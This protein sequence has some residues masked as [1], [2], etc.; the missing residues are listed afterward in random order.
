MS[1]IDER[2]VEMKFDNAGFEAG[3]KQST[4]SLGD[5]QGA[6]DFTPAANSLQDIS[7]KLSA[8]G[9]V[10]FTVIQ[11][12]TRGA[13]GYGAGLLNTIF[14]PI[15][16]GGK[17][18][19]LN[20]EQA[21]FQFKG[22]GM[23]VEASMNSAREAVLGTAY[24]LDA[25][26]AVASQL[27][28]SGMRAG[29]DMTS[30][31]RGVS[32]LAAMTG[33]SYE[34]IGSIFTTVAGN[35]RLMGDQ[36]LQLSTRGINAA[37]SLGESL[38][39]TEAQVREMVTK[40]EIDFETFYK[41]MDDAFGKHA[42]KASETFN[43]AMSNARAALSRIGAAFAAVDFENQRKLLNAVT[44]VID[45][46]GKAL[47]PVV[48]RFTELTGLS[49][50][51][52][53]SFLE[54]L[55]LD[56]FSRM[57]Y[58]A[59]KAFIS[60]FT[61]IMKV[62]G[63]VKLAFRDVFPPVSSLS[64]L[65]I[66][67]EIR[68]FL[69]ALEFS[70]RAL[71]RIR[72]TF[73]G[74]FAVF[75]IGIFLVSQLAKFVG[76]LL[77]EILP[78]SGIILEFSGGMG[79]L[80]LALRDLIKSENGVSSFFTML[81]DG[82]VAAIRFIRRAV[83]V[84]KDFFGALEI[85]VPDL[86]GFEAVSDIVGTMSSRLEGLGRVGDIIVAIF[87]GIV[88]VFGAIWRFLQPII[89]HIRD[90]AVGI[91]DALVEA[92][93]AADYNAILDTLNI[94]LL[95]SI[96]F[97][98]RSFLNT[99]VTESGGG[100]LVDSIKTTIGGITEALSAMTTTLKVGTLL[101]IAGAIGVLALS[102]VAL[103][104]VDSDRLL[105]A[106]SAMTI[107]FG[108]L[109]GFMA[110][111]DVVTKSAGFLKMPIV[112]GAMILLGIAINILALAVRQL[113]SL[114]WEEMAKGLLGVAALLVMIVKVS[115]TLKGS[116]VGLTA[117]AIAMT[118]MGVAINILALAVRQLS[119]LSWEELGRG[120]LGVLGL[121]AMIA[122]LSQ[123]MKGSFVGL[124]QTAIAMIAI[125]VAVNILAAAVQS[126]ASMSWEEMARGLTG[127]AA[128]LGALALFSRIAEVNKGA[129]AQGV[130]LILLAAA[131]KIF[132]SAVKDFG[133]MSLETM[134]QGL[135]GMAGALII[136]AE[137]MNLMPKNMIVT[138]VA[139]VLVAASLKILASVL[140]TLGGMSWESIAKGLVTLAGALGVIAGAMYLMSGALP[141]AA[142][143]LLI[144]GALAVLVPVLMALGSMSLEQIGM[145]LLMLVGVFA[146]LAAAGYLLA[147]VVL[148][149]LGLS[150]A[151]LLIGVAVMLA[152]VG[153]GLLA[154][155]VTAL[156]VAFA[157]A[158]VGIVA[159]L[160][161]MVGLIPVILEQI[162]YGILALATVISQGGPAIVAA[163]VTI[164]LSLVEAI[165]TVL[166]PLIELVVN[167]LKQL[168]AAIVD[169]VPDIIDA[170]V[171]LI[172]ALLDAI[173]ELVP[174]IIETGV[175]LIMAFV[176]AI[177]NLVPRLVDAGMR[178]ITGILRG[179]GNNIGRIVDEATRI[180][181]EFLRAIGRNGP[182]I[183]Q[184][185]ANT[186]ITL[187]EGLAQGIR[188]NTARMRAAAGDLALA[189]IDG[190]TGGLGSGIQ[191]AVN[192]AGDLARRTLSA[193]QSVFD[194]NSPSR[195]TFKIGEFVDEGLAGGIDSESRLVQRSSQRMAESA[196]DTLR[197]TMSRAS[198]LISVEMDSSPTIRPVLD[199]SQVR[200]QANGMSSIFSNPDLNAT[201]AYASAASISE[202]MQS[203]DEA[204]AARE[205][206]PRVTNNHEYKQYNYSP[207]SLN[208]IDIY[209]Q[210]K[211]L[212]S[213]VKED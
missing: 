161:A 188:D 51:R 88:T 177:V 37:A 38:G 56:N 82:A 159:G 17:R 94:G 40:G 179:I 65:E 42:T 180:V 121:M 73:Q 64:I 103:A 139:L 136:V 23:D 149:I 95:T 154:A 138:S 99:P 170:A 104:S 22:L 63:Q 129:V 197:D 72:A 122:G 133:S 164:L 75:D 182:K 39:K 19:A 191:R 162:G 142:A 96:I 205:E 50:K 20:I 176:E 44:P 112:A 1:S 127:V 59:D 115:Q 187:V 144:A 58:Q 153:I 117:T 84:V 55:D 152:G 47:G 79:K 204:R 193:I 24:G 118:V 32:G 137:A 78:G 92:F 69:D 196:L 110:V 113:S 86:S 87:G 175:I 67:R 90:F 109:L 70:D 18:R 190:L 148:V 194:I 186:I 163:L 49:V 108:Q 25:A 207:E 98:L 126:F 35:G 80:M 77:A 10:A 105:V 165:G 52:G 213:T 146:L 8:V 158:G 102:A 107:M 81:G 131:L 3:I 21:Q 128:T 166:P 183:V 198:D 147:P 6:L 9:A 200:Q 27:G 150:A 30:A 160:S 171:V 111:F 202:S 41:A 61:E 85:N 5:L 83:D 210:T 151:L 76:R 66:V 192:A 185:G 89:G 201:G 45:D 156:G 178:L 195:E 141:G 29:E 114:S 13:I 172:L 116:L 143:L 54:G 212:I 208:D 91:G 93:Q 206:A 124:T 74:V 181:T 140:T 120:L 28:A 14:E 26:A 167:I 155:G 71:N 12:L 106:L 48:A 11:D 46:I 189:I 15:V 16:E 174:A 119:S 7:S 199:L 4:A 157:T 132:A 31:L 211:N 125:G 53:V 60:V 34:D 36:L 168:I 57:I 203:F 130:G 184:E 134:I 100:G 145:S 169:L 33:S 2:I 209:R 62:V 68:N 101:L 173:V 135:V 43:G 97:A 123:T